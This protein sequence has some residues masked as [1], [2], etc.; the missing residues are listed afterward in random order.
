[1]AEDVSGTNGIPGSAELGVLR[2]VSVREAWAHEEHDFTVWLASQLD[3][4]SGVLGVPLELEA[5]EVP[6]GGFRADILARN[7]QDGSYVL[8]E[9]QL[10]GTDHRHLGQILTYAAGLDAK[11]VIWISPRFNESHLAALRWLN[12]HFPE[13]HA[14][15][16]IQIKVVQIEN[17]P[18]APLFEVVE[19]PNNWEKMVQTSARNSGDITEL[20]QQRLAFWQVF[21]SRHPTNLEFGAPGASSQFWRYS[22]EYAYAISIYVAKTSV[23]LFVRGPRGEPAERFTLR[24]QPILSDIE[25]ELHIPA[26]HR[27]DGK[28]FAI[29]RPF[30]L[31][32]KALWAEAADWLNA[33]ADAYQQALERHLPQI[34]PLPTD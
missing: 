20:G 14:F 15:I 23:G 32:N 31:K 28:F 8:I 22:D 2:E 25:A 13:E 10:E 7:S 24:L 12:H 5:R 9:N 26:G 21:F 11:T 30:E 33:Q 16:G 18:L 1:M 17:S 34:S 19:R 29:S 4:L 27:T 6:V 3:Q